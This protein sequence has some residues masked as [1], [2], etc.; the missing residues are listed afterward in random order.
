M[1]QDTNKPESASDD[2]ETLE[3]PSTSVVS[4][5]VQ[6]G[7]TSGDN[8]VTA[9]QPIEPAPDQAKTPPQDEEPPPIQPDFKNR[10]ANKLPRFNLYLLAVLIL[11]VAAI[12]ITIYSFQKNNKPSRGAVV[13]TEPLDQEVLDQLKNSDVKIGDPQQILSVEANAVFAGTVLVRGGL[14]VA[15]QIKVGGPLSLPGITVSGNSQFDEVNINNLQISGNTTVQRQLTVQGNLAVNGSATFG[16][17]LSAKKLS[18]Q[19]L[20]VNGDLQFSR[21]ID[22]GGGAP[23]KA[24]GGA[25]G[26]GGTSSVSGT[27]TAGTITINTGSNPSAGC[28]AAITFNQSFN[29]TPHV[30]V[31]PVGFWAGPLDFYTKRSASNFSVCTRNNPS[32]GK[33]FAFDYI[34]ID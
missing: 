26:S 30:V 9:E 8:A 6:G 20:Q 33:N 31:T 28:F 22:A 34:V 23:S 19:N 27:D 10:L 15:G 1:D 11:A 21:H 2:L 7:N 25:L 32:G 12:G 5:K 18:I 4:P 3:T 14:E 29:S 13:E 16:G 24:N 17:T